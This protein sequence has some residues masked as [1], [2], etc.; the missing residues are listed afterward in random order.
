MG[1]FWQH[2]DLEIVKIIPFAYQRL[3]STKQLSWN[4]S[5]NT[6]Q[7]IYPLEQKLGG[8][9]PVTWTLRYSLNH[10]ICISKIV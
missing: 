9:F 2:G 5:T 10:P 7:T 1:G 6:F 4:S 8:R 3:P